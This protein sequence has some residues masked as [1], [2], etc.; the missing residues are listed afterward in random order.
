MS[1]DLRRKVDANRAARVA[2]EE[3]TQKQMDAQVS[4]A[5]MPIP[6]SPGDTLTWSHSSIILMRQNLSGRILDGNGNYHMHLVQTG[7]RIDTFYM[8]EVVPNIP[9]RSARQN[10]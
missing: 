1:P 2:R 8:P 10:P 7:N 6:V 3:A 4:F 5:F 9:L